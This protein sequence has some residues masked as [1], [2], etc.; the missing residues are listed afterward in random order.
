MGK[1]ELGIRLAPGC[2]FEVGCFNAAELCIPGKYDL[3]HLGAQ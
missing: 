1:D 3:I 2:P